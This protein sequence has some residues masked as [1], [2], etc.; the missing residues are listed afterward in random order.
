MDSS[1]CRGEH[2]T[3][4]NSSRVSPSP[5]PVFLFSFQF[6]SFPSDPHDSGSLEMMNELSEAEAEDVE[7]V[8]RRLSYL[9]DSI[10]SED[11]DI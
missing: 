9:E 8:G 6:P 4:V 10:I 7:G 1:L 2:G 5:N 3:T 11:Q